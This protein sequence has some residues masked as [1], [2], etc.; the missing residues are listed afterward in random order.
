MK[1]GWAGLR[2]LTWQG[3]G[4]SSDPPRCPS[5]R[6]RAAVQSWAAAMSVKLCTN[7]A[8]APSPSLLPSL[9][10]FSPPLCKGQE[11]GGKD[12]VSLP[13]IWCCMPLSGCQPA[14]SNEG[15]HQGYCML[16]RCLLLLSSLSFFILFVQDIGR[17]YTTAT[18][19]PI[20][21]F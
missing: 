4:L 7:A 1:W 18:H 15:C 19:Q 17:I 14:H 21:S 6:T 5:T 20:I 10:S 11:E 9:T 8:S 2:F 3:Q 16:E 13:S 12:A